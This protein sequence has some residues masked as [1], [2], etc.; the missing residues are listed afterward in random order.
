MVGAWIKRQKLVRTGIPDL[1]KTEKR[2][3][4]VV[5]YNLTTRDGDF[6]VFQPGG[7]LSKKVTGVYGPENKKN[8]YPPIFSCGLRP[9]FMDF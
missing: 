4:V 9:I 6:Y 7:Y 2:E 8:K 5:L 1:E 3:I